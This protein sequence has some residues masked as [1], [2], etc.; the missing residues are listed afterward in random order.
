MPNNER[1]STLLLLA[2]L[3]GFYPSKRLQRFYYWNGNAYMGVKLFEHAMKI[4]VRVLERRIRELVNVD[5]MQFDFITGRKVAD[6][7][8]IEFQERW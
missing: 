8:L 1:L 5:A 6:R 4:N 7:H 3:F 2:S